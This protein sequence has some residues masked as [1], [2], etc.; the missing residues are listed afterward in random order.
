VSSNNLDE[1]QDPAIYD[2]EYGSSEDLDP[3]L[4]IKTGG[5]ALDLACGTGRSTIELAKSGLQCTG[6]D[7]SEAMLAMAR[8]KSQGLPISYHVGDMRS[9]NFPERFDLITMAGDDAKAPVTASS[10]SIIVL[11]RA[12]K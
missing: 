1:Y 10:K 3:F 8:Q 11:C 4:G 7:A 9:F 6:L 5:T 12:K 2:A